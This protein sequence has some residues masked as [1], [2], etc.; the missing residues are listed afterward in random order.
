MKPAAPNRARVLAIVVPL[1][2]LWSAPALADPCEGALPTQ[3]ASFSGVVR[4]VGDG[5]GLCVGP[6]NHPEQWI[7]VRLGDFY[8]PE[9]HERGGVDAKSRLERI[10][11]SRP[12]MCRAGRRSYDRVIGYCTLGGRPLGA[13]LRAAGGAQGGRGF[14]R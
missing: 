1:A 11:M 2:L 14:R 12:L 10:V 6:A 7:E 3:G 4:Y 8:A 13:M 9:L 5:D